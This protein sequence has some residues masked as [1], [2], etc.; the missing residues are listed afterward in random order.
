[1]VKYILKTLLLTT[2]KVESNVTLHV[3]NGEMQLMM[4][5]CLRTISMNLEIH[6]LSFPWGTV[7]RQRYFNQLLA[8]RKCKKNC[9]LLTIIL[10]SDVCPMKTEIARL[11]PF[12][13]SKICRT[14]SFQV[15]LQ[16]TAKKLTTIYTPREQPFFAH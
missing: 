4:K 15:A 1:M 9:K 3:K 6:F 12:T 13:C 8:L 10:V 11:P 14:Q 16:W 7:L 5:Y 2:Q